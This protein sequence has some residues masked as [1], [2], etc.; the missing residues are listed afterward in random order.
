MLQVKLEARTARGKQKLKRDGSVWNIK[1]FDNDKVLLES[2]GDTF[3]TN[4]GPEKAWRWVKWVGDV[5]F[6]VTKLL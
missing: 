4:K 3:I 2:V 6:T 5:D 1:D